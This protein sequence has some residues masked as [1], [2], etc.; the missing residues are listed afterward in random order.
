MDRTATHH[1]RDGAARPRA[2]ETDPMKIAITGAT[3]F[4]GR[5]V[6]RHLAERGHE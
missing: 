1:N 4:L 5:H 3:G 6:A 2:R